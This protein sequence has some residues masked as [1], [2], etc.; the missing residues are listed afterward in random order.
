[1]QSID[2]RPS[3][4]TPLSTT[5]STDVVVQSGNV[6]EF[7]ASLANPLQLQI[8][9]LGAKKHDTRIVESLIISHID[10]SFEAPHLRKT[11]PSAFRNV[12]LGSLFGRLAIRRDGWNHVALIRLLNRV[13]VQ[14][15]GWTLYELPLSVSD[16]INLR[17]SIEPSPSNANRSL[18]YKEMVRH[19]RLSELN[20]SAATVEGEV[21]T[22]DVSSKL[23][24]EAAVSVEP[25]I[26]KS[27]LARRDAAVENATITW[28][29]SNTYSWQQREA[30]LSISGQNCLQRWPS[31]HHEVVLPKLEKKIRD[32]RMVD[33]NSAL[34]R[35]SLGVEQ[36][37][38]WPLLTLTRLETPEGT[39][40]RW[41]GGAN[42]KPLV[43]ESLRSE[44]TTS[45]EARLINETDIEHQ[46]D[47]LNGQAALIALGALTRPMLN[48]DIENLTL[49]PGVE[50]IDGFPCVRVRESL[51]VAGYERRFWIDIT[52]GGIVRQFHGKT[53]NENK[54][55]RPSNSGKPMHA[56]RGG[57]YIRIRYAAG[58]TIPQG[59][60]V[61]VR[62]C[63]QSPLRAYGEGHVI[64]VQDHDENTRLTEASSVM[65]SH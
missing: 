43:K 26:L 47:S 36:T 4:R 19:V 18:D 8:E 49:M 20:Q 10:Q 38:T 37:V 40:D 53:D 11:E 24:M 21:D 9:A 2:A 45:R 55:T 35:M 62:D 16:Q 14:V 23:F 3:L 33:F 57:T 17:V 59:W 42:V 27:L 29:M 5:T 58:T 28:R 52:S 56:A 50:S 41:R 46:L 60:T 64:N 7:E 22:V 61:V 32:D 54:D 44:A 34:A 65:M 15:N 51:K 48:V 13:R 31:R 39:I 30:S 63:D 1:M 25:A 12:N 6:L